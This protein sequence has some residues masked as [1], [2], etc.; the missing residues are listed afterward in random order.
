L[1]SVPSASSYQTAEEVLID[2]HELHGAHS[3]DNMADALWATL[4]KYG[5]ERK[6]RSCV[7][8]E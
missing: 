8:A 2:F 5:I 6:V 1:V 4:E 3:G 7:T